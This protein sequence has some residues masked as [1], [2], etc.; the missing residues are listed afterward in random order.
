MSH[1]TR[2]I[3]IAANGPIPNGYEI[4]HIDQDNTNDDLSNLRLATRAENCRNRKKWENTTSRY[5]GVYWCK[6][7][8]NWIAQIRYHNKTYYIGKFDNE[9]EAHL[10]WV[11]STESLYGEFF[12]N[13]IRT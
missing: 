7:R 11:A 6:R 2:K 13:G 8:Q 10:A 12:N 3:W 1:K 9:Y 4:D 5:K